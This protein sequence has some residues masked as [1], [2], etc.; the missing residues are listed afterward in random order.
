MQLQL[1]KLQS[2]K[3]LTFITKQH[4]RLMF[5]ELKVRRGPK[6]ILHAET[7]RQPK[8]TQTEF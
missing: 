1:N 5:F 3:R 8:I 6:E 2:E 7:K 4:K